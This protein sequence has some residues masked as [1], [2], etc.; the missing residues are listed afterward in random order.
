MRVDQLLAAAGGILTAG[1]ADT[2]FNGAAV[3]SR[4][5]KG[6]ELFVA[7]P[8]ARSD[9]HEYV[10]AAVK[11]GAA[12]VMVSG[13]AGSDTGKAA[14]IRVDDTLSALQAAALSHRLSWPGRV[15]G[16]TGSVGKTGTREICA[17][18]LSGRYSVLRNE[19]NYNN[20]IG[21]PLTLLSL[22]AD[23]EV[24]VIEMGMRGRGEIAELARLARPEVGLV[25]CIG[26]THIE[27]LGS[28]ENIARA[29]AEL[30][31]AL[32]ENGTAVLPVDD[33]YFS[34]LRELSPVRCITFGLDAAADIRGESISEQE[35]GTGFDICFGGER[36]R[37]FI[38]LPG[39]H[40][41]LNSLA[42]VA[43]AVS[44]G[45]SLDECTA[46]LSCLRG[47]SMRLEMLQSCGGIRI[48]SDVYNA[49]PA[50]VRAAI[51]V[52]SGTQAKRR[53]A[54]LAD[55]L[56]LGEASDRLHRE[57]GVYAVERGVDLL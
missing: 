7:L 22:T 20:E 25:T 43:T 10:Q 36:A 5:I 49:S 15:A 6:G 56:E 30:I 33:Q 37:A 2:E 1:S 44:L 48:I 52:L 24:A 26:E 23:H 3:D 12:A 34:L 55:M 19:K 42:A 14:V 28:I 18:L 4:C 11:A 9:G 31:Q 32:P 54:V 8:G 21:V 39:R 41:V 51:D 38:P 29:K 17:A 53:I 40:N 46:G 13:E 47:C 16:V 57:I 50:S 45:L 27:R 35:N